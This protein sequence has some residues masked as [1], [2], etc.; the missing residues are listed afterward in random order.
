MAQIKQHDYLL[1]AIWEHAVDNI[2]DLPALAQAEA[3]ILA[4][5]MSL[6][7]AAKNKFFRVLLNDD[8]NW[9]AFTKLEMLEVAAAH[10]VTATSGMTKAEIDHALGALDAPSSPDIDYNSM[11][12]AEL[13]ALAHSMGLDNVREYWTKSEII[14]VLN[15]AS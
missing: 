1:A 15:A 7:E 11:T 5:S 4:G 14:A 3:D 8:R 12:K 13:T 6:L 9:Q 2:D 10:N